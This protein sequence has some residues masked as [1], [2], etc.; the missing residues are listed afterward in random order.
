M[1]PYWDK[2]RAMWIAN[3]SHCDPDSPSK[4]KNLIEKGITFAP[5]WTGEIGFLRYYLFHVDNSY[6]P[7]KSIL[8]RIDVNKGFSPENCK[9]V[10]KGKS[11]LRIPDEPV[12]ETVSSMN[13]TNNFIIID[14][15]NKADTII[16]ALLSNLN[17]QSLALVDKTD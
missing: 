11:K 5:E 17:V 8:Q 1:Y 2:I 12:K 4:R 16:K 7:Q 14:N 6:T 3:Q 9:I 13:V 15:P 10:H